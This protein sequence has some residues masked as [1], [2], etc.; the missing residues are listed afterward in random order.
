MALKVEQ[1]YSK[2]EIITYYLNSIYYGQGN[3]GIKAAAS[4]YFDK[5][6]KDLTLA[7]NCY[8]SFYPKIAVFLY[9]NLW[10]KY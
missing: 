5:K 6:L 8:F 10:G 3:L 7:E 1:K 4:Y 2:E 9:P